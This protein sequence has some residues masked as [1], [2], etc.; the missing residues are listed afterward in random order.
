MVCCLVES[1]QSSALLKFLCLAEVRL[2]LRLVLQRLRV[3]FNQMFAN[4]FGLIFA[5]EKLLI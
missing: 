2:V 1:L 5:A 4:I 3:C